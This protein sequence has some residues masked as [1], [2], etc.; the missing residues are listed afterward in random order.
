M[1]EIF[2]RI[3][4]LGKISGL[5]NREGQTNGW[6]TLLEKTAL[7]FQNGVPIRH[8]PDWIKNISYIC[9]IKNENIMAF[10]KAE[11][12]EE[13]DILAARFAKALS[14]PARIAIVR[15]LA[16]HNA[17][18]Y[19]G[20]LTTELPIAQSTI[21]QHLKVLKDVGLIDG[22]IAPPKVCY[23]INRENLLLAKKLFSELL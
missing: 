1:G 6:Q 19:C 23:R 8:S 21:S 22:E 7:Q 5:W 9:D 16:N 12:F 11:E 18:C 14:H 17:C 20:D 10:S 15:L 4:E 2:N 3:S 13:K